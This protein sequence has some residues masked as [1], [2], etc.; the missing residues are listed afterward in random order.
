M[1]HILDQNGVRERGKGMN[2][3]EI[4]KAGR[5]YCQTEGS[6]HY[7]AVDKLEPMDLII[8]KGLAEDFCLA[9][10]IKYAS[11]FKQTQKLDDLRKASDYCQILCGVKLQNNKPKNNI[12]YAEC[13]DGYCISSAI[14]T[15]D[16]VQYCRTKIVLAIPTWSGNCSSQRKKAGEQLNDSRQTKIHI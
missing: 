6:E 15:D 3:Y 13:G 5:E 8:A 2:I 9:N 11:R 10:I 16:D 12:T 1:I 14:K 7:K 4:R